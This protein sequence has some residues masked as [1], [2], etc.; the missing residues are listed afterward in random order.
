[1]PNFQQQGKTK[2]NRFTGMFKNPQNRDNATAS[3]SREYF[4]E[5]LDKGIAAYKA[6]ESVRFSYYDNGEAPS[7]LNYIFD[8]PKEKG[9]Q[10]QQQRQGGGQQRSVY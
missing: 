10:Q 2:W 8:V 6:G 7:T 5:F 4:K 3:V 9:W 1:M